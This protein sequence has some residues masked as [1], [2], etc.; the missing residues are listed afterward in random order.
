MTIEIVISEWGMNCT[1]Q[2]RLGLFRT[3]AFAGATLLCCRDNDR[4]SEFLT[5]YYL[6]DRSK[7]WSSSEE[8]KVLLRTPYLF[9]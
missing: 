5:F 4:F 8:E 1:W 6:Y 2:R 7:S 9:L 3:A